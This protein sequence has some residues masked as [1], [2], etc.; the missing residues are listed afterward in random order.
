VTGWGPYWVLTILYV[1][2]DDIVD[3]WFPPGPAAD[4]WGIQRLNLVVE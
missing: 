1:I 3:V 2:K 4:N